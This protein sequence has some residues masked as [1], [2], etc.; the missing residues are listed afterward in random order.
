MKF[1]KKYRPDF[2]L[3]VYLLW[4]S[5]FCFYSTFDSLQS[6]NIGAAAFNGFVGVASAYVGYHSLVEDKF[7]DKV[8]HESKNLEKR[9]RKDSQ[10]DSMKKP[11]YKLRVDSLKLTKGVPRRR[12]L[13][14]TIEEGRKATL[15]SVF[16]I[17]DDKKENTTFVFYNKKDEGLYTSDFQKRLSKFKQ[18]DMKTLKDVF[19]KNL[20]I[21]VPLSELIEAYKTLKSANN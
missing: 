1:F 13:E 7:L 2:Y 21:K 4:G 19:D 18:K 17:Y 20:E 6:G 5:G 11:K 3:G 8:K 10:N 15:V 12:S 9:V 14:A 16:E